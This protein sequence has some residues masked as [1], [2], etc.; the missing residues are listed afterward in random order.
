MIT[1]KTEELCFLFLL[2]CRSFIL[3]FVKISSRV[4]EQ[5]RFK[6]LSF[7]R[8][9]C[10]PIAHR[11]LAV[12]SAMGYRVL[13]VLSAIGYGVGRSE[14]NRVKRVCVAE[15]LALPTSVHA[16]KETISQTDQY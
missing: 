6:Y 7:G 8:S 11:V 10:N 13:A 2:Q 16:L 9:E 3:G 5:I 1:S 15:W 4:F 12:L 14:C